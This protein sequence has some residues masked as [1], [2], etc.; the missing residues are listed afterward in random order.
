MAARK[1]MWIVW[2]AFL[3]AGILEMVVF[4]IIDPQD[5]HWFG[6]DAPPSRQSVYTLMFFVFWGFS[7]LSSSLTVLLSMPARQV[8]RDN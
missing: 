5:L 7:M 4:A 6:L 8:N 3:V 2:P 1:W